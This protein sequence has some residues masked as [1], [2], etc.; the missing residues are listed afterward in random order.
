MPVL[1]PDNGIRPS[2]S[3]AFGGGHLELWTTNDPSLLQVYGDPQ[4]SRSFC[5]AQAWGVAKLLFRTDEVST[6]SCGT[7]GRN[8]WSL[9]GPHSSSG[10]WYDGADSDYGYVIGSSAQVPP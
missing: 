6:Y 1:K 2:S 3:C 5:S 8:T 10:M 4:I 7:R 9:Q